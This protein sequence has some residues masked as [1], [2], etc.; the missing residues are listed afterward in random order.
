M[1][2]RPGFSLLLVVACLGSMG[3]VSMLVAIESRSAVA[4]AEYRIAMLRAG[5]NASALMSALVARGEA[6][7][8]G[9]NGSAVWRALDS[10]LAGT[11][12]AGCTSAVRP[13]GMRISVNRASEEALLRAFRAFGLEAERAESLAAAI[14]DWRDD[15]DDPRPAGAENEWYVAQRRLPPSNA[16]F[17]AAEELLRVRGSDWIPGLDTFFTVVDTAVLLTR[18]PLAV[19][20]AVEGL[21][22][23]S[24]LEIVSAR[25]GRS[26][27]DLAALAEAVSAGTRHAI[28]SALPALRAAAIVSPA[29]WDLEA[30]CPGRASRGSAIVRVRV[31]RDG[32]RIAIVEQTVWP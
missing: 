10:L 32:A 6:A 15:D 13:A 7:L 27:A 25:E 19:L 16:P 11:S 30:R 2:R 31:A 14:H 26:F 23:A 20:A 22:V 3:L 17:R 28:E 1:T 24:A 18:A 12:L 21:D 5:W 8:S 4:R 29:A 9:P